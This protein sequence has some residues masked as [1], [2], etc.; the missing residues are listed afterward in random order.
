M[1]AAEDAKDLEREPV[2]G[3]AVNLLDLNE[4]NI[5]P[6]RYIRIGNE[7]VSAG[8]EKYQTREIWKWILLLAVLLL[9]AEWFVY[10]RRIA[11]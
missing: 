2:R 11:V 9:L 1:S 10:Q 3:F 4:S 6:R 8:E 5:E 7:R